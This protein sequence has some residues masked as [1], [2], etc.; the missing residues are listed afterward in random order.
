M[1]L[2]ARNHLKFNSLRL[3]IYLGFG[4]W[5]LGFLHI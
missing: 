4:I 3:E 1:K 5:D 2:K